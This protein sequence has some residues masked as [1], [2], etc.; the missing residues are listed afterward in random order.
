MTKR[1][2]DTIVK[3]YETCLEKFGDTHLGVDWPKAEDAASRYK[4]MLDIIRLAG[5]SGENISLLDFGCGAAH[6]YQYILEKGIEN[7]N[8]TGLDISEKFISLCK[9]K[10]PGITFYQADISDDKNKLPVFDY[11]VI[12]GVFTEKRELSFDEMWN[13]FGEMLIRIYSRCKR[14]IAFNVMS[15]EVEWERND[16]F[17]VPT[18]MLIHFLAKNLGRNFIIRNDYGLYEYTVYVYKQKMNE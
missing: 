8:Y 3:H 2:M 1:Y 16:L 13:Y 12:N 5:D 6:L 9:R 7:I 10:Y 15:K 11:I 18:D 14:G 17:H 4:V